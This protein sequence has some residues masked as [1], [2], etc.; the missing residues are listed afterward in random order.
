MKISIHFEISSYKQRKLILETRLIFNEVV[1]PLKKAMFKVKMMER[2]T[3]SGNII[4][5][6]DIQ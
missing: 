4:L 3:L 6:V 2:G 5:K 1:F